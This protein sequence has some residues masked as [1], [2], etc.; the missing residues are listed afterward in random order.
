ML[1][2]R[3]DI[4]EPNRG[5][6]MDRHVFEALGKTRVVIENGKVTDVG[7]PQ[8]SYCPL[9][10]KMR[11]IEEFT[12]EVVRQNIE[13][14]IKDFGMCTPARQLRMK[15]FLS[16]G[17][18][19][20]LGMAVAEKMLDCAVIVCEGAGTVV[21]SEPELIQGIG[22]RI[23]GIVETFPILEIIAAI[24]ADYVLD[25]ATAAIDQVKGIVLAQSFGFERIGVTISS[26]QDAF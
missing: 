13:F 19:E 21:A 25:P 5:E 2:N 16:F 20:L 8:V 24:G 14:R 26:A 4:Y 11:G 23:S 15:D 17:V 22:G 10:Y 18:S 7:T 12:P 6:R 1:N 9:F 3:F